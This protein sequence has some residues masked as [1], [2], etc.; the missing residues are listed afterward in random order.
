[1]PEALILSQLKCSSFGLLNVLKII[2]TLELALCLLLQLLIVGLFRLTGYFSTG[3]L[4]L[5]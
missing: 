3:G 2:I 5:W 4:W 1:M